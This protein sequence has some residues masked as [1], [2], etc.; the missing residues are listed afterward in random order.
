[1]LFSLIVIIGSF[2][3]W[4]FYQATHA[5]LFEFFLGTLL[6]L[7]SILEIKKKSYCLYFIFPSLFFLTIYYGITFLHKITFLSA[8]LVLAS[9]Y[10]SWTYGKKLWNQEVKKHG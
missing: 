7:G 6:F 9:I 10:F 8:I 4:H 3:T 5:F 1:M 2:T